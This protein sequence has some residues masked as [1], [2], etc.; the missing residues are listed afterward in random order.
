MW[1]AKAISRN[2]PNSIFLPCMSTDKRTS[3]ETINCMAEIRIRIQLSLYYISNYNATNVH[4]H[5][6]QSA[7]ICVYSCYD[8][9]HSVC[10]FLGILL[11]SCH[12][13][14]ALCFRVHGVCM[15]IQWI[16]ALLFCGMNNVGAIT[17]SMI[18]V[19]FHYDRGAKLWCR[20]RRRRQHVVFI[21]THIF[22]E[23][24]NFYAVDLNEQVM[25][26]RNKIIR[27]SDK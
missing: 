21:A 20:R 24:N 5:V 15:L 22:K 23:R 26:I 1:A 4:V 25:N 19:A 11:N 9:S 3:T 13:F 18:V 12:I 17:S 10:R 8:I 14:F 16:M 27:I 7:Y 2:D 6:H